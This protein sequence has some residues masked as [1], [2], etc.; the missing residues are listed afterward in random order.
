MYLFVRK[1]SEWYVDPLGALLVAILNSIR[2]TWSSNAKPSA[3]H[4][5]DTVDDRK[6]ALLHVP[7]P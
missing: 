5:E 1:V 4:F 3:E 2:G 6:P 7:K